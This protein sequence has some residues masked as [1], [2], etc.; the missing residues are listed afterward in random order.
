M[1]YFCTKIK[2]KETSLDSKA[3]QFMNSGFGIRGLKEIIK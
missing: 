1:N 2:W 3:F